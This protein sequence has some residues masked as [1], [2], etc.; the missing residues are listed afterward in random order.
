MFTRRAWIQGLIMM[1]AA[2]WLEANLIYARTYFNAIPLESYSLIGNLS[3]FVSSVTNTVKV[4]DFII[5]AM[6]GA[7]TLFMEKHKKFSIPLQWKTVYFIL[8]VLSAIASY[9]PFAKKGGVKALIGNISVNA[10]IASYPPVTHGLW[11]SLLY[12]L[13]NLNEPLSEEKQLMVEKWIR[14]HRDIVSNDS[15]EMDLLADSVPSLPKNLFVVICES[16]ESWPVGLSVE[17]KEITPFLNSLIGYPRVYYNANVVSQVRDGRSIDAQLLILAGQYPLKT[18][19]F[20]AKYT[21]RNYRAIPKYM[22]QN[23]AS[24]Y[25]ITADYERT[26]FQNSVAKAFGMEEI[27]SREDWDDSGVYAESPIGFFNDGELVE[28]SIAKM[29][30]GEIWP[31][32]ESAYVQMVTLSSHFPFEL[33]KEL[34]SLNLQEDYPKILKDYLTVVNYTDRAIEKLIGYLRS[35]SDYDETVIVITG[36]HEGLA[37]FREE[38]CSDS[39]YPWVSPGQYTPVFIINSRYEGEDAKTIGQ[40]DI[41]S[42]LVDILNIG[43]DDRWYGMGIS[44]FRMSHKGLAV[45]SKLDIVGDCSSV[46]SMVVDHIAKGYDVSDAMIRHA[47]GINSPE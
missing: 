29:K 47:T 38:I 17:G 7:V 27:Y 11:Y 8:L 1:L 19:A 44:P 24:T 30:S 4:Y 25:L 36:D 21:D 40:V 13:M 43:I 41:Y 15:I 37:S 22:A 32:G 14:V 26:W 6:V 20:S 16:L 35:R 23:G 34:D 3:E 2:L 12:D 39:R 33:N 42:A 31:E 45:G 10:N 46:D 5:F 18:G 28:Q 9:Y